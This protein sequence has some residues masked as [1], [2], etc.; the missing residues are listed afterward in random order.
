MTEDITIY[1]DYIGHKK[2]GVFL[3]DPTKDKPD[4]IVNSVSASLNFIGNN[5]GID[6]NVEI[7]HCAEIIFKIENNIDFGESLS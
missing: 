1:V 3:E 5:F 7:S 6:A 4:F 2:Y